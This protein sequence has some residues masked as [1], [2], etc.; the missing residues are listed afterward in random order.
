MNHHERPVLYK[1][2]KES[3]VKTELT[4]AEIYAKKEFNF[5]K[6]LK[7]YTEGGTEN[8]KVKRTIGTILDWLIFKKKFDP[9]IVGAALLLTFIELKKGKVFKGDGS[10]VSAGN[11]L[12]RSILMLCSELSQGEIK[13]TFY[14]TIAEAKIEETGLLIDKKIGKALPWFLKPFSAIWWKTRRIK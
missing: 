12:V 7:P 11:E 10:Y 6:L 9:K 13:N 3:K 14:K 5:E 1:S 2:T 8:H 4:E